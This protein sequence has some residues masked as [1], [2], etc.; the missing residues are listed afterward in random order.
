[1]RTSVAA[2]LTVLLFGC[3]RAP[4]R[5]LDLGRDAGTSLPTASGSAPA[6]SV[7]AAP[8]AALA[9]VAP[10]D[11][12]AS[13]DFGA[14]AV[15]LRRDD[16]GSVRL[17]ESR[18]FPAV[19]HAGTEIVLLAHDALDFAGTAVEHIVF[20]DVKTG[21][22]SLD[23]VVYDEMRER[24]LSPPQR[25]A[26]RRKTAESV[27][28]AERRLAA[29]TWHALQAASRDGSLRLQFAPDLAV[30]L[31]PNASSEH[32]VP[33]TVRRAQDGGA[34][35]GK[36]P[37]RIPALARK[38]GMTAPMT[39]GPCG[40]VQSVDGWADPQRRFLLVALHAAVSGDACTV[41]LD[42]EN[43]VVVRL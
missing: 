7:P 2:I 17:G 15:P 6:T 34:V 14:P 8:S 5:A 25:E 24:D 21:H 37:M 39:T 19:N 43:T 30:E 4:S 35:I 33:L 32:T 9:A 18:E 1:M 28:Q 26:Q 13:A 40:W 22:T 12:A 10:L 36:V 29:T 27:A 31:P 16:A 11:A 42:S 20:R 41:R 23:A 38:G 3:S